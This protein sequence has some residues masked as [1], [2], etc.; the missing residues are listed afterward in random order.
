MNLRPSR[1]RGPC[2]S[3]FQL[4]VPSDEQNNQFHIYFWKIQF[5][6]LKI[7]YWYIIINALF[8]GQKYM[9]FYFNFQEFLQ[10]QDEEVFFNH[11][12]AN[13]FIFI[14]LFLIKD[15]LNDRKVKSIQVIMIALKYLLLN[16]YGRLHSNS[17]INHIKQFG[18]NIWPTKKAVGLFF[19]Y[20]PS[21]VFRNIC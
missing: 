2:F 21:N 8:H 19:D 9:H 4:R 6:C 16:L 13:I 18:S 7:R 15:I 12:L 11:L 10:I 14:C 17:H 20:F 1:H 3:L 5:Y